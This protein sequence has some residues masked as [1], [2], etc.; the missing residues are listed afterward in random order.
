MTRLV[1]RDSLEQRI[2]DCVLAR[3]AGGAAAVDAPA[4]PAS[5]YDRVA[6]LKAPAGVAGG[7][8]DDKA[9]LRFD[10]LSRLFGC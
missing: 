3:V 7:L 6:E 4:A 2:R 9:A 8:R 10:E 5:D 1:V